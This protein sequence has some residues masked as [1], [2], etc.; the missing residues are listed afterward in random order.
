MGTL[1][2]D[3]TQPPIHEVVGH[4]AISGLGDIVLV[5]SP[6]LIGKEDFLWMII[7]F[8]KVSPKNVYLTPNLEFLQGNS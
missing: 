4:I 1:S 5:V 7:V 2:G 6:P 3:L 8:L